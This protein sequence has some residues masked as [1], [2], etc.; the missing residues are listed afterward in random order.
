MWNAPSLAAWS[1]VACLAVLCACGTDAPTPAGGGH[2][3]AA[4]NG[5]RLIEL[6]DHFANLELL[7]DPSTGEARV[8][9]LDAHAENY[10]RIAA[11]ELSLERAGHLPVT[12]RARATELSGERVGDCSRFEGVLEDR[13]AQWKA[14][15]AVIEVRGARFEQVELG[16]P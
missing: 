16:Y 5:G 8:H 9:V 4:P 6:G 15:L 3:H 12:L 2:A 13:P 11:P 10:T 1:T 14:R 7:Y